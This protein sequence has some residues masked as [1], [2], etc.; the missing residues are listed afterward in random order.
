MIKKT[1]DYV[2]NRT[3]E[4]KKKNKLVCYPKL[5]ESDFSGY[6][7]NVGRIFSDLKFDI[8]RKSECDNR[9]KKEMFENNYFKYDNTPCVPKQSNYI[10]CYCK[11]GI[12]NNEQFL[13]NSEGQ[14]IH[15]NCVP[16]MDFLIDWFGYK[17]FEMGKEGYY[18]N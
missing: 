1:R 15:R 12:Y 6:A 4:L 11:K 17:N 9:D 7:L 18:D 3:M 8:V 5:S 10:C 13:Q 16:N 14:Y 2:M